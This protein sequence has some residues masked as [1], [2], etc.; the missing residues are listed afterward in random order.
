MIKGTLNTLGGNVPANSRGV[1]LLVDEDEDDR[2]YY[3]TILRAFGYEVRSCGSYEEGAR[4]LDPGA[5]GLVIVSQGSPSFEGR[6]V[7]VSATQ[8]HRRLPVLVV[9]RTLEMSC[10]LE[11]MQLGAVDYLSEPIRVQDLGRAVDT[12][13]RARAAAQ[14]R[15]LRA[16]LRERSAEA[17]GY[18]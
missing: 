2:D 11:A 14:K 12:H 7:L 9:A 17:P 13:L 1:V 18:P 15:A 3:S 5:F 8:F 4:L 6:S 10:Y 16:D